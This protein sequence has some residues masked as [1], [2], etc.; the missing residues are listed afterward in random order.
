MK[1]GFEVDGGIGTRAT[2][3]VILLS[4]DE[5]LEPEF[6]RMVAPLDE[7]ALYHSRIRMVNEIR[8]DTLGQMEADLP[9]AA[10]LLPRARDF[11]VSDMAARRR[12]R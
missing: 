7:V 4:A 5:T 12:L 2:L 9:L 10:A 8:A 3:G 1:L 6:A 11:D